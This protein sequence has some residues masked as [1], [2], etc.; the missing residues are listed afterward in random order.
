MNVKRSFSRMKTK[1][2]LIW[3]GLQKAALEAAAFYAEFKPARTRRWSPF[4]KKHS[5][6]SFAYYRDLFTSLIVPFMLDFFQFVGCIV[7]SF[8]ILMALSLKVL[9]PALTEISAI[10]LWRAGR[11]AWKNALILEKRLSRALTFEHKRQLTAACMVL[12]FVLLGLISPLSLH[13]TQ[14]KLASV[15]A[16]ILSKPF[17]STVTQEV[18]YV[19]PERA[20][21]PEPAAAAPEPKVI[22]VQV[23]RGD[24]L[25]TIL[26]RNGVDP[27]TRAKAVVSLQE[28]FDARRLQLGQKIELTFDPV[29][30]A[31]FRDTPSQLG[32]NVSGAITAATTAEPASV[33]AALR[34]I[35]IQESIE[36]DV[37][38]SFAD[39]TGDFQ[40]FIHHRPMQ[41]VLHAAEGQIDSS[42][43]MA[44]QKAG[45]PQSVMADMVDAFAFD[46]DFQREIRSGDQFAVFYE[47]FYGEDGRLIKT[48]KLMKAAL[49]VQG[50]PKILYGYRPASSAIVQYYDES[51]QNARRALL[52]TPVKYGRISSNYGMRKHPILGYSKMHSGVDFAAPTGT[53]IR[54]AG[55][56]VINYRARKGGYGK[57]V[58]IRHNGT[59]STAYAH[60]S[61]YANGQKNGT[62]VKQGEIIGYVG[63]TGRSTG[64][65]LHYEII[66][67]GKHTNP[68]RV[69]LPNGKKLSSEEMIAFR[70]YSRDLDKQE[71]VA[72]SQ[73]GK[74]FAE[75]INPNLDNQQTAQVAQ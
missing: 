41:R 37:I 19:E 24:T 38:A 74:I 65:H 67:N 21:K 40:S 55:D 47:A 27:A 42:L 28:N 44:A 11:K 73:D 10:L 9:V 12:G 20:S 70:L 17:A 14:A 16:P 13:G 59:Y 54:A 60:L 39:E 57:Y 61:R 30:D 68:M 71:A 33:A 52:R 53:P 43:F 64:P 35:R 23:R 62:R 32:Q 58:R 50:E 56:G 49:T 18:A 72:K 25:G 45:V 46:V 31:I 6:S 51:G 75:L 2:N 1:V 29:Q 26:E 63:S 48:G 36:R 15:D 4:Q 3:R 34:Q 66:K 7:V 8:T 69:K 5:S 22:T